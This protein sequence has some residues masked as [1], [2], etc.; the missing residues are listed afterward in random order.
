MVHTVFIYELAS[1]VRLKHFGQ[2]V[3]LF[4]SQPTMIEVCSR[5]SPSSKREEPDNMSPE[6]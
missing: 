2:N 1:P 5:M 3:L 6:K 4:K